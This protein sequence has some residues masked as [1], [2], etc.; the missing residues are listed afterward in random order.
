MNTHRTQFTTESQLIHHSVNWW[1]NQVSAGVA[2][3]WNWHGTDIEL[4][5]N[6]GDWGNFFIE[7]LQAWAVRHPQ[8][9]GSVMCYNVKASSVP[10]GLLSSSSSDDSDTCYMWWI[11][12]CLAKQLAIKDSPTKHCLEGVDPSA[13]SSR[14]SAFDSLVC[15]CPSRHGE[16][17]RCCD[18]CLGDPI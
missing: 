16:P 10:Q 7:R 6:W 18:S 5:W 4:K 13:P 9:K 15:Y 2:M 12:T 3:S 17:H 11:K 1:L 14:F 8:P